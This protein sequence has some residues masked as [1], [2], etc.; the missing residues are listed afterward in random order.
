[1]VDKLPRTASTY[2]ATNQNTWFWMLPDQGNYHSKISQLS[3]SCCFISVLSTQP[4]THITTG[5]SHC[6]LTNNSFQHFFFQKNVFLMNVILIQCNVSVILIQWN[7]LN[8]VYTETITKRMAQF[9][10]KYLR[11][12]FLVFISL[13]FI[14]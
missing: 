12:I 2:T 13:L 14:F 1:M 8:I 7:K 10:V 4:L 11:S 3:L 9:V 6:I 5:F